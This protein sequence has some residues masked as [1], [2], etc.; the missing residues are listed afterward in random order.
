MALRLRFWRRR[1]KAPD[2]P[3][4]AEVP[5]PPPP[6]KPGPIGAVWGA[7]VAVFEA[8]DSALCAF[9][10]P[11]GVLIADPLKRFSVMLGVFAV[12]FLLGALPMP[13]VPLIAL[14]LAYVGVLAIGRAW[15]LN[16][17]QRARI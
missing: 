8:L 3:P 2:I 15:V 9:A 17:K 5:P 7:V 10:I 14:G 1:E 4:P 11:F 13:T 6:A 16:E 12:L